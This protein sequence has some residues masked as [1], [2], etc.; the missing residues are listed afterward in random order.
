MQK[1]YFVQDK[2]DTGADMKIAVVGAGI[3]GLSCAYRLAQSGQDVTLYE[4][5]DYF[6]GHSHTVDVT[7]GGVTHGVDTGF[8]VFNH[9]TYHKLVQ[10][11]D[12]LGVEAADSDLSFYVKMPLGTT[13][14]ARVLE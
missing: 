5:G 8:L 1:T 14:G 3:A 12:E 10:L 7:L 11:F 4:A 6:G 2:Y 13:P 9:A